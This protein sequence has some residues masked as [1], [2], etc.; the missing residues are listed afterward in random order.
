MIPNILR[1][2]RVT[3]PS[4]ECVVPLNY[5]EIQLIQDKTDQ[6][7]SWNLVCESIKEKVGIDLQC[8]EYQL[9]SYT[10]GGVEKPLY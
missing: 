2:Q 9:L 10:V 5:K 4:M 1:F 7:A 6:T 8:G 3:T